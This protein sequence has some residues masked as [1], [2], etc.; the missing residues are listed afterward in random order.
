[1]SLKKLSISILLLLGSIAHAAEPSVTEFFYSNNT[2][3]IDPQAA[4]QR[5][6]GSAQQSL[7]IDTLKL[8][9][10]NH[11]KQGKQDEILGTYYLL[12]AHKTTVDNSE[13][14]SL[15]PSQ[16]LPK[17]RIF[18]IARQIAATFNQ[19]SVAVFIPSQDKIIG[20]IK[21]SF[22]HKKPKI[23]DIINMIHEKLPASYS[24]AFTLHIKDNTADYAHAEVDAV[25]W[26]GDKLKVDLL[27][28]VFPQ[29]KISYHYGQ[30]YLI[31]KN[32]NVDKF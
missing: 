16:K 32:G 20:D 6:T 7:K 11:I 26:L 10:A 15:S 5:F 1:M 2:S 18:V 31:Y 21:V 14:F 3:Q 22:I 12:H 4:Y 17:E 23:S 19:E 29:E 27:K 8:M 28:H 24:Q 25:E 13:I 9:K 30:S